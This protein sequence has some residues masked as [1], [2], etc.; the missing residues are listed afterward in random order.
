MMAA[1]HGRLAAG[2]HHPRRDRGCGGADD[3]QVGCLG[4]SG[5]VRIAGNTRSR[6]AL[7]IDRIEVTAKSRRPRGCVARPSPPAGASRRRSRRC[8]AGRISC[9]GC[10][11]SRY[12]CFPRLVG[13][14]ARTGRW[15]IAD[16]SS[17]LPFGRGAGGEGMVE[18]HKQGRGAARFK[19]LTLTLSRRERGLS[20]QHF[21]TSS[22]RQSYRSSQDPVPNVIGHP[23]VGKKK[24]TTS[25]GRS[26]SGSWAAGRSGRGPP[27]GPRARP[28][29]RS[30][31]SAGWPC[32]PRPGR[33][34]RAPSLRRRPRP[35]GDRRPRTTCPRSAWRCLPGSI[36]ETSIPQVR[37]SLRKA[38]LMR[39]Q[40]VLRGRVGAQVG[41]GDAAV[42]RAHVHDPPA[43]PPQQR[44]EGLRDR[45]LADDVDLELLAHLVEGQ[46]F[47][48]PGHDDPGVIDQARQ[49]GLVR[50]PP[51]RGRRP[52]R[53]TPASVT[54]KASGASRGEA[55]PRSRSA[56][57]SLRTPAKTRYPRPVQRQAAGRADA[58]RGAGNDDGFGRRGV[59]RHVNPKGWCGRVSAATSLRPAASSSSDPPRRLDPHLPQ[60]ADHGRQ[61][62]QEGR[63]A[64]GRETT[65]TKAI[66][67]AGITTCRS[68]RAT[69]R[70][71]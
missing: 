5:E 52:G 71:W 25:G 29:T 23:T 61:V 24:E 8:G 1:R 34:R 21:V 31:P 60:L 42:E 57:A 63:H 54:S 69:R 39:L 62:H 12:W 15:Q 22:L 3:G 70:R 40:G 32:G 10:G 20:T 65:A 68:R 50:R 46:E 9:P 17:P 35:P 67:S 47:Q 33:P 45:D 27:R 44:Q 30:R 55:R 49:A 56:S 37:S 59:G 18:T 58:R 36:S 51:R 48:R 26:G 4:H 11:C 19:A 28:A 41:H 43:R 2:P 14:Q 66:R 6:F 13:F 38:S 64:Q 7:G 16:T 53:S